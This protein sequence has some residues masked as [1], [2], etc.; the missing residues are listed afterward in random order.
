VR[1]GCTESRELWVH[2]DLPASAVDARNLDHLLGLVA[3]GALALRGYASRVREPVR[4]PS[5]P[6]LAPEG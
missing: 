6:W 5:S 4:E 1:F 3:E 2:A